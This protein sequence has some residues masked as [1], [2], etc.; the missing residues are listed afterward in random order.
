MANYWYK[1]DTEENFV[2]DYNQSDQRCPLSLTPFVCFGTSVS[3]VSTYLSQLEWQQHHVGWDIEI[4]CW[5][6]GK[7]LNDNI[8]KPSL[9]LT[10]APTCLQ[11][12]IKI[13]CNLPQLLAACRSDP[14]NHKVLVLRKDHPKAH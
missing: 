4:I 13:S 10:N 2:T 8:L 1:Q 9:K 5:L 3:R 7:S 6:T 11:S 12:S 14:S